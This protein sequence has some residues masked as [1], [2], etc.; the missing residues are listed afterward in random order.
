M[1][2]TKL[3][4]I[5][6]KALAFD[7]KVKVERANNNILIILQ[8]IEKRLQPMVQPSVRQEKTD[9]PKAV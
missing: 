4:L 1:D 8:E 5:E 3:S 2:L 6:L 9:E 7:E